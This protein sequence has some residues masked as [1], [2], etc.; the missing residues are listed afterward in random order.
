MKF[1]ILAINI[2]IK[3]TCKNNTIITLINLIHFIY[4][5]TDSKGNF[6]SR[7]D[8]LVATPRRLIDHIHKTSGF[9]LNDLQFLVIDEADRET[10]D[11]LQQLPAPHFKA[12]TLTLNNMLNKY[13]IIIKHFFSL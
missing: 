6:T 10:F 12:P 13:V 5:F 2:N 9:S 8:I 4:Y 1:N 3:L 11:W 7:I